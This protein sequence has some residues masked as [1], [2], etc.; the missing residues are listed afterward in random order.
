MSQSELQTLLAELSAQT[1]APMPSAAQVES[2]L[3]SPASTVLLQ[4]LLGTSSSELH[5]AVSQLKAGNC[6]AASAALRQF[7]CTAEGQRF[8]TRM[9]GA[10]HG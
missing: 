6:T 5:T 9:K 7:L 8:V 2:F 10:H 3:R 1:G 4:S